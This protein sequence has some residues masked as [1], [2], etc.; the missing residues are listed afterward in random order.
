MHTEI[1]LPNLFKRLAPLVSTADRC[2]LVYSEHDGFS[3]PHQEP[4]HT[5]PC[6]PDENAGLMLE[7]MAMRHLIGEGHHD[8]TFTLRDNTVALSCG[9]L[10][11]V[12]CPTEGHRGVQSQLVLL[13]LAAEAAKKEQ[14]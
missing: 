13:V 6:I 9:N 7:A 2:G 1:T 12:E 4:W 11:E 5:R 10:D 8:F 14:P 3:I